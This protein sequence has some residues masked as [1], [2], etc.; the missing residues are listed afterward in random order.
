MWH[1]LPSNESN[2][3][4]AFFYKCH[5]SWIIIDC[6]LGTIFTPLKHSKNRLT[7]LSLT[8]FFSKILCLYKKMENAIIPFAMIPWYMNKNSCKLQQ[9]M[10]K[11]FLL[12]CQKVESLVK[13]KERKK[14]RKRSYLLPS[15]L[16]RRHII[17]SKSK[18][19]SSRGIILFLKF[20][21]YLQNSFKELKIFVI[22]LKLF[23][24]QNFADLYFI[25]MLIDY[26]LGNTALPSI[27]S[28]F[29]W[30]DKF[31]GFLIID[32]HILMFLI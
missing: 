22:I 15:P 2:T 11:I 27:R 9:F 13:I 10:K 8:M 30:Y 23:L 32:T 1:P 31:G 7:M 12:M 24:F 25:K 16:F 4:F 29:F 14:S 3:F 18:A 26:F 6:F 19:S 21:K 28:T 17:P 5:T 20:S